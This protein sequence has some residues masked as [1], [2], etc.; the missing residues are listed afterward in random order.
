MIDINKFQNSKQQLKERKIIATLSTR[1]GAQTI[2]VIED[3]GY[4]IREITRSGKGGS[5]SSLRSYE[6]VFSKLVHE[7]YFSYKIDKISFTNISES[8]KGSVALFYNPHA[9][10][11]KLMI[12][13][14]NDPRVRKNQNQVDILSLNLD[15]KE[16]IRTIDD[17]V[18]QKKIQE[19]LNEERHLVKVDIQYTSPSSFTLRYEG[20]MK[21]FY[22][23]MEDFARFL[24]R[25][26]ASDDKNDPRSYR[27]MTFKAMA[28]EAMD[29][30]DTVVWVWSN[31]L[32]PY[33][34]RKMTIEK[35]FKETTVIR[36][37]FMNIFRKYNRDYSLEFTDDGRGL[38]YGEVLDIN[39][40][41]VIDFILSDIYFEMMFA[42]A[43]EEIAKSF[44]E[45]PK[46]YIA[47][48]DRFNDLIDEVIS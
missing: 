45:N 2:T 25:L 43:M 28:Q 20:G 23:S 8:L 26:K 32:N 29:G 15:F 16:I 7:I 6:E 1:G 38:F 39:G 10:F 34:S 30:T 46:Y 42:G 17:W 24:R 40:N 27:S 48:S 4:E 33:L 9:F 12:L 44:A 31:I 35:K 37:N 22:G 5:V 14:T 3:H 21:T 36:K 47:D 11:S 19:N 18:D 41:V 13:S